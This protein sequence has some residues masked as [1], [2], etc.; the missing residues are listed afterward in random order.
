MLVPRRDDHRSDQLQNRSKKTYASCF[1]NTIGFFR[2]EMFLD[3]GLQML[4]NHIDNIGW[5]HARQDQPIG[6]Q[7]RSLGDR[8]VVVGEQLNDLIRPTAMQKVTERKRDEFH[9]MLLCRSLTP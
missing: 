4:H 5:F 1:E 7:R 9:V 8:H 3:Q 6:H 2:F